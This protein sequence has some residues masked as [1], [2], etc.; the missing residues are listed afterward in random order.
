MDSSV[1]V[2]DLTSLGPRFRIALDSDTHGQLDPRVA[3]AVERCAL[4]VHA[5]DIGSGAVLDTLARSG[6]RVTA[7]RGNNDV[8]SKWELRANT[9]GS[10]SFHGRQCSRCRAGGWQWFTV[11]R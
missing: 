7:V 10:S 2:E 8:A 11:I 6:R 3:S 9:G 1:H 5:G 4:A